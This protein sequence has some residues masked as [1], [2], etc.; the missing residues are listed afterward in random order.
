MNQLKLKKALV[1]V[2]VQNDFCPSG[3][4]G[5]RGGDKI[6]PVLNRYIDLFKKQKLPVIYSRDW[7]PKVTKH[8]KKFGGPWPSHCIQGTE[9]AKFHPKLKVLKESFIL[10]KG[11]DPEKDSYSVFH[12]ED[13]NHTDFLFLLKMLGIKELYIGGLAT[14]YCVKYTSIDALNQG[15]K[16][17]VLIDAVKGV[18]LRPKDSEKALKEILSKGALFVTLDEFLRNK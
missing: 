15:F 18:D 1:V 13:Q 11:M 16:V 12:A 14:D 4:L 3:A 8:F 9:G 5:I 7:H 10:S 17:Y 2:D 6:I